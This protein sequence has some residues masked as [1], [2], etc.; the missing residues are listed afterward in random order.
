QG[1]LGNGNVLALSNPLYTFTPDCAGSA[2][3]ATVVT[4]EN[5]YH[6]GF[7]SS[8]QIPG[9]WTGHLG[10]SFPGI[11]VVDNSRLTGYA[12]PI[13]EG[14]RSLY[15]SYSADI[16]DIAY[17][18]TPVFDITA[19]SAPGLSFKRQLMEWEGRNEELRVYYRA[20]VADSWTLLPDMEFTSTNTALNLWFNTSVAL[21]SPS[22][23]YQ[24]KFEVTANGGLGVLI[25]DV[26]IGELI[27]CV[28]PSALIVSNIGS[29]TADISWTSDATTWN[30]IVSP[31]Q[32]TDFTTVTPTAQGLTTPSYHA[33]ELEETTTYYVYVQSNCGEDDKSAWASKTFETTICQPE[34]RC[35]YTVVTTDGRGDGWDGAGT[36]QFIQKGIVIA[37]V[38]N[39]RSTLYD[40]QIFQVSLCKGIPAE[41][42]WHQG[43]YFGEVAFDLLDANGEQLF[44]V[45]EGE[46]GNV[47]VLFLTNP[48][49]T[50]TPCPVD[51][52]VVASSIEDG[53][54]AVDPET[55]AI[56]ITLNDDADVN[57]TPDFSGVTLTAN[58]NAVDVVVTYEDGVITVTLA[59]GAKLEGETT[60]TLTIPD[61]AVP[62]LDGATV[63]TFTTDN[64]DGFNNVETDGIRIY[65]AITEGKVTIEAPDGSKVKVTD[66]TGR[67][68]DYYDS[69]KYGQ[70]INISRVAGTYFVIVENGST[71]KVQKIILK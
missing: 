48:L 2:C 20:S 42:V 43:S 30:V 23:T 12:E 35:T 27:T 7:E 11:L 39:D 22:A 68:V 45:A 37:A 29:E 18:E 4:P 40:P 16:G 51:L 25:D 33:T 3:V 28:A 58:G 57:G 46:L 62:G 59:D 50:F 5:P 24:L 65:P 26:N 10:S 21:P 61:G 38:R 66:I 67:T 53:A 14:V 52:E 17:I 70:T 19:L 9:C 64:V 32:I 6:E 41:L 49:Y 71:R 44:A 60:Y 47:D 56:T 1:T 54:V 34:D 13:E 69:I 55:T 8:T 31:V 63:I 36:L 15:I